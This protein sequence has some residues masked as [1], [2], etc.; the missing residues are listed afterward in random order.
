MNLP[1]KWPGWTL[2]IYFAVTALATNLLSL[3]VVGRMRDYLAT[4]AVT[5]RHAEVFA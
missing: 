1:G 2:I 4:S 5:A 3:L